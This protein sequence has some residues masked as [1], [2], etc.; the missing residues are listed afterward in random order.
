MSGF[1]DLQ[2]ILRSDS[3][4]KAHGI[5]YTPPQLAAYLAKQVVECSDLSRLAPPII[6][7]LDPACGE[8]ELLMAIVDAMPKR[9]RSRLSITGFDTDPD[10]IRRANVILCGKGVG[11][12]DFHCKDFLSTFSASE[13]DDQLSL[14]FRNET[15]T[16]EDCSGNYDLVISNPPYVRTQVLG[17]TA[18]QQLAARFG[19]TGRVDLYH[20]FIKA[21][22]MALRSGGLLGL[23]TSNRFLSVQS[24][25]SVRDWLGSQ[26]QLLRLVDLGDTKLFKA[27]VLPAI[28]V[29]LRRAGVKIQDCEY[30]RVYEATQSAGVNVQNVDSVLEVLDG[31]FSGFVRA[32]GVCFQVQLGRLQ[33]SNESK[34]P[35][36]MSNSGIDTWLSTVRH[37]S[38]GEFADVGKVCVGIKTTADSVFIRDDWEC[39][40][41]SERPE[42]ELLRPLVTHHVAEKWRL[43]LG[44]INMKR[45]LYPYAL[46][47]DNRNPLD[48][49]RFPRAAAYLRK[50]EKTLRNRKYLID[51]GREWYEIWVPQRPS[52][53]TRPKIAFP[54]IS[55]TSKFFLVEDGWIVNGDCYWIKLLPGK[56]PLFLNLMLAVA[57]STFILK[58]YDSVFHNKLYSGRRRFMSQYVNRFPL[59]KLSRS[60]NII[61]LIPRVLG[62]CD[63]KDGTAFSDLEA[64]L[65]EMVWDAFGLVKEITR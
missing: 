35:W 45:V 42:D 4:R 43:P 7:V 16:C 22:T 51:A 65:D 41:E 14:S 55:E 9:L 50:H 53:W 33:L 26:F 44:S 21:M 46:T 24:G 18:A 64:E 19:L 10:A 59:P 2:P 31:T 15:K 28:V 30:S 36:A 1:A 52:D 47:C 48:L 32:S 6:R 54:D 57:N 29:G 25:S 20:A 17:A 58:F 23:L 56:N 39:L 27:A 5:H 12:L 40:A 60:K 62:A 49:Q 3:E 8:G 37:N 13:S 34:R 38:E 63:A 11:S 61:D